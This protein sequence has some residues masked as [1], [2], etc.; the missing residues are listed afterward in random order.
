MASLT[1]SALAS[2]PAD[3]D[4]PGGPDVST[5]DVRSALDDLDTQVMQTIAW[6]LIQGDESVARHALV[7]NTSMSRDE[8][9]DLIAGIETNLKQTVTR[10]RE[11]AAEYADQAGDYAQ[12]VL[13]VALFIST[14]SIGASA[15]GGWLGTQPVV[16]RIANTPRARSTHQH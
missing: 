12:G 7:A 14:L 4:A 9:D 11:K 15:L 1:K 8:A 3:F 16:C 6:R 5:T 10:Y 2:G 13:W